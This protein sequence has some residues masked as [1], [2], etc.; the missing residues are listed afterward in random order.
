MVAPLVPGI[1]ILLNDADI[2]ANK[3]AEAALD[4]YKI[5]NPRAT[6]G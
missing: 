6:P 4:I 2:E 5:T 3:G 1:V